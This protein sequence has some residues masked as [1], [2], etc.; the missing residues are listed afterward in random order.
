M[1]ANQRTC[2]IFAG[3]V[4]LWICAFAFL[5]N[6]QRPLR[7]GATVEEVSMHLRSEQVRPKGR[8]PPFKQTICFP[9]TRAWTLDNHGRL[10]DLDSRVIYART[11]FSLRPR[12]VFAT[13][14]MNIYFPLTNGTLGAATNITSHWK[15]FCTF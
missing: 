2:Y 8:L 15:W 1:N 14:Y 5:L 6:R 4:S 7:V 10:I 11:E 13:R 12:H 3:A 9:P